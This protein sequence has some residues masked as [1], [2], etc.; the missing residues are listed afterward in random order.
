MQT[1]STTYQ[2]LLASGALTEVRIDVLEKTGTSLIA[3]YGMDRI[4]ASTLDGDCRPTILRQIFANDRPEVGSVCSGEFDF[5]VLPRNNQIPRMAMVRP[6]VRM[7]DGSLV[8]EWLPKGIFYVSRRVRDRKSGLLTFQCFDAVRKANVPYVP[9]SGTSEG[10][11]YSVWRSNQRTPS[12]SIPVSALELVWSSRGGSTVQPSDYV[13]FTDGLSMVSSVSDDLITVSAPEWPTGWPRVDVLV[14]CEIC[15][16][17]GLRPDN[18]YA[19]AAK[20]YEVGATNV[21]S[22]GKNSDT[23]SWEMLGWIAG[24]RAGNVMQMDDGRLAIVPLAGSAAQAL[25]AKAEELVP[26]EEQAPFGTV[27]VLVDDSTAPWKAESTSVQDGRILTVSCPWGSAEMA[28][29]ILAKI[30]GLNPVPF[31]ASNV[32]LDP[33][34]EPGDSVTIDG[35]TLQAASVEMALGQACVFQLEMPYDEE[36]NE[37]YPYEPI[38]VKQFK[39]SAGEVETY[40][41][42]LLGE[43][44]AG[45]SDRAKGLS[46]VL[47]LTADGLRITNASGTSVMIDGGQIKANSIDAGSAI[48]GELDANHVKITNLD[49]SQITTGKLDAERISVTG[50][51]AVQ[52]VDDTDPDNPVYTTVGYMGGGEGND[53]K[54]DTNGVKLSN[55]LNGSNYIFVSNSGAKLQVGNKSIYVT[56]DGC[57]FNDGSGNKPIGGGIAVFG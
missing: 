37:E 49:A 52:T 22:T 6:Y 11:Q 14:W 30:D 57:F 1:A 12:G 13:A 23:T 4:A 15:E 36:L 40:F 16:D 27:E 33:L 56:N 17:I 35:T 42:V 31:T 50:E 19:M 53:G 25:A 29:D 32:R 51:L 24:S 43:I 54:A 26:A 41:K 44:S 21:I 5:A 10:V 7:N 48:F 46:Q 2:N 20:V 55:G 18:P 8:S 38:S 45:V 3:S 34:L 28:A 39:R 9:E 47:R